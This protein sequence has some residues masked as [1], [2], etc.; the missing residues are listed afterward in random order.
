MWCKLSYILTPAAFNHATHG[1]MSTHDYWEMVASTLHKHL[2]ETQNVHMLTGCCC[3]YM[4]ASWV[5]EP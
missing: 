4:S 3:C 5:S 1:M 2:W